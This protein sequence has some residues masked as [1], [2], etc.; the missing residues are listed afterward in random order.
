M[1]HRWVTSRNLQSDP[2]MCSDFISLTGQDDSDVFHQCYCCD[3][4]TGV[5]NAMQHFPPVGGTIKMNHCI[6]S[7]CGFLVWIIDNDWHDI[8]LIFL[9]LLWI[10]FVESLVYDCLN[11]SLRLTGAFVIRLR[12]F[13]FA[14]AF[15]CHTGRHPSQKSNGCRQKPY[16]V[17]LTFSESEIDFY[18]RSSD[19]VWEGRKKKPN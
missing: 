7:S 13:Y 1:T 3:K 18:E 12:F 2:G 19:T 11:Q 5:T 4:S 9:Q 8:V 17:R 14:P 6:C 15:D 16:W 10:L